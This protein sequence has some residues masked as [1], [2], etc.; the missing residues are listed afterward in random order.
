MGKRQRQK[1]DGQYHRAYRRIVQQEKMQR[2]K[3]IF[4][5]AMITLA[6]VWMVLTMY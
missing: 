6:L 4:L 2:I 3:A 1:Q 5:F